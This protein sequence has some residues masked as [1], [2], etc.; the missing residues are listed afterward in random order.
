MKKIL[1]ILLVLGAVLVGLPA[2][3]QTTINSTT[4]STAITNTND[5]AVIA[6]ASIGSG[7]TAVVAGQI[8]FVDGEAMVVRT[9]PTAAANVSVNRH[10][11]S[12]RGQTHASGAIVYYGNA[13]AFVSGQAGVQYFE[14]SCTSTAQ[15]YLPIIDT[16][17]G[18]IGNCLDSRWGW[19]KLSAPEF[20][21]VPFHAVSS[22]AY[23]AKITDV[24][25]GYT[26]LA[27]AYTVTLPAATGL[28]GKV[29]IVKNMSTI[30][31]NTIWVYG[32]TSIDGSAGSIAVYSSGG[33]TPVLGTLKVISSGSAWFSF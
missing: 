11:N 25:I 16:V 9:T 7:A 1:S 20:A 24:V 19:F 2:F 6:L 31:T 29:Y 30:A 5:T 28:A 4:L 10:T 23:T 32:S 13:Q 22:A 15:L 21:N 8:L 17:N 27:A 12:T 3:A 14:G 18:A 26:G 33:T